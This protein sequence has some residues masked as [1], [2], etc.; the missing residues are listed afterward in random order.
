[1]IFD[2]IAT[3]FWRTGTAWAADRCDVVPDIL[4]MGKALTG[5]YLTLAAVLTTAEDAAAHRR[6]THPRRDDARPHLHG[7]PAR[8]RSRERQ[9]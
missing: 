3:G 4:C 1:M 8:L 5:G 7:E 6:L 2:E 9:P